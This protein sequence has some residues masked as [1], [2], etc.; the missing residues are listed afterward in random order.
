MTIASAMLSRIPGPRTGNPESGPA[1]CS[2][3]VRWRRGPGIGAVRGR[4]VEVAITG[5]GGG[6]GG[7]GACGG[8]GGGGGAPGGARGAGGGGKRESVPP[9]PASLRRICEP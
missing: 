4:R 9:P 1:A 3:V 5:R 2:P 7:G 8:G 6:V